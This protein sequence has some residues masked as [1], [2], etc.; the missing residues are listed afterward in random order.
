MSA[1]V[2]TASSPVRQRAAW[3]VLVG[4]P[5]VL[6][7]WA[8]YTNRDDWTLSPHLRATLRCGTRPG[9]AVTAVAIGGGAAWL[10]HHLQTLPSPTQLGE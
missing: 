5:T 7:L 6:E 2:A 4:V 8:V 9:N 1:H 3:A 10:A